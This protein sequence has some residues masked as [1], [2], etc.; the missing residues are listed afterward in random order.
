MKTV[1]TELLLVD[2]VRGAHSTGA[3]IVKRD[4]DEMLLAKLPV[5]SQ[6]FVASDQ[7]QELMKNYNLKAMIGHNRYAT[8]GDKIAE[9]AHPFQFETVVGA[10][11]GTLDRWAITNISDGQRFG[12]DSESIYYSI[13]KHGLQETVAKLRGAWA[14]T[15]YDQKNNSMNLLR[16]DKRPLYYCYSSDR[17]TL[18]WASEPDM[19]EWVLRRNN[20][21]MFNDEF[22]A[23]EPDKHYRWS[24]PNEWKDKLSKPFV[25]E[26]KAKPYMYKAHKR[27]HNYEEW[28]PYA[29]YSNYTPHKSYSPPA[30]ARTDPILPFTPNNVQDALPDTSEPKRSW[31]DRKIDTK[32]FRP[33]YKDHIGRIVNKVKF[34][35]L[36]KCGCIFCD[37]GDQKWG[38]FILPL[39]EDVDGRKNYLCEE[40][41]ND[42]D[43]REMISHIL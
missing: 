18:F 38:E 25:T 42:D 23:C 41:Y 11:N 27:E 21:K 43:I 13:D 16:N 17:G 35:E 14:L 2:V 33:P 36:V 26:C 39:K 34:E 20:V 29:D 1:F 4:K 15:W 30:I 40:C 6:F 3:A 31:V 32:K 7:Y 12:T 5:A 9:N 37:T 22:Y 28:G 8:V 24:L 10:H 19:L